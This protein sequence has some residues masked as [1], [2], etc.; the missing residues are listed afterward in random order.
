VRAL[1]LL[2]GDLRDTDVVDLAGLH[3]LAQRADRLLDRGVGV[4]AVQVAEVDAVGAEP[5]Q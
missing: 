2:G 1:E 5:G 3:E 4:D